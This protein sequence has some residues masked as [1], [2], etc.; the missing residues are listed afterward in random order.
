MIMVP[1]N[2]S[3][4]TATKPITTDGKNNSVEYRSTKNEESNP[5]ICGDDNQ[6]IEDE[7]DNTDD[8]GLPNDNSSDDQ[9][10]DMMSVKCENTINK[11]SDRD[12]NNRDDDCDDDDDG[13]ESKNDELTLEQKIQ[14]AKVTIGG[15]ALVILGIFL[16]PVPILPLGIPTIG[17]GLHVLGSEYEEARNAE[18]K[19]LEGITWGITWGRTIFLDGYDKH[20]CQIEILMEERRGELTDQEILIQQAI[21]K[22]KE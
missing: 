18:Q 7:Y 2:S 9:K 15:G 8:K 1:N 12:E 21:T 14:R 22:S 6:Q 13:G 10:E 20:H 3:L 17:V 4:L 11:D 5:T 19:L 16:A